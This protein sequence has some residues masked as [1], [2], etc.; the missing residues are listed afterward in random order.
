[1]TDVN[2][3]STVSD[4]RTLMEVLQVIAERGRRIRLAKKATTIDSE[5]LAGDKSTM[6]GHSPAQN[7]D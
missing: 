3:D 2:P 4:W 7:A 5:P 6:V 1:M